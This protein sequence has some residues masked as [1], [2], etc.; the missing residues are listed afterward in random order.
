MAAA[1]T[2][3]SAVP[4]ELHAVVF[5]HDEGG[6]RYG[7]KPYAYD[8][9]PTASPTVDAAIAKSGKPQLVEEKLFPVLRKLVDDFAANAVVL[10]AFLQRGGTLAIVLLA[11]LLLILVLQL[12]GRLFLADGLGPGLL[13]HRLAMPVLISSMTGGGRYSWL[14]GSGSISRR[15]VSSFER[16]ALRADDLAGLEAGGADA[17][18]LRGL[19]GRAGQRVHRLDVRV[20]AAAGAPVGVADGHAEAGALATHVAG[21][22]HGHSKIRL[23]EEGTHGPV[24]R[25]TT[26]TQ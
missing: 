16:S 6:I 26:C 19:A 5:E 11:V 4:G 25:R 14:L 7:F 18:L 1:R 21:R 15:S 8:I 3:A 22:S 10:Q 23:R 12:L 17:E 2:A 9:G 24:W 13:G 20:P